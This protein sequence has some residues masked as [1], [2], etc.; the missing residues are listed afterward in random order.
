MVSKNSGNKI[1]G[2]LALTCEAQEATSVGDPVHLTGPMEVELADGTKPVLGYVSVANTK[3]TNSLMGTSVGNPLVP[4]PVTVETPGFFV[5]DMVA[6]ATIEAGEE[7][8]VGSD[9]KVYPLNGAGTTGGT[10]EVQVL[11]VATSGN[12][13][14]GFQGVNAPATAITADAA[15]ATTALGLINDL[16]DINPGDFTVTVGTGGNAGKLLISATADGDWAGQDVPLFTATGTGAGVTTGTAGV[17]GAS[18]AYI[19]LALTDAEDADDPVD[20]LWK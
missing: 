8:G 20:V 9:Q 4:G 2:L 18:V 17:A 5:R 11:T 10:N 3:R 1:T 14:L 19:G 13:T 15:G 12:T 6:G 7:V 16:P